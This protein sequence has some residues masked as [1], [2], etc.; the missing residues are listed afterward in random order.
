M[1]SPRRSQ[2]QT[3]DANN[4]RVYTCNSKHYRDTPT[5]VP[6]RFG[7]TEAHDRPSPRESPTTQPRPDPPNKHSRQAC[8]LHVTC[9]TPARRPLSLLHPSDGRSNSIAG[10]WHAPWPSHPRRRPLSL[11]LSGLLASACFLY[12]RLPFPPDN[13]RRIR[14]AVRTG[15]TDTPADGKHFVTAPSRA[16]PGGAWAVDRVRGG[17]EVDVEVELELELASG[18]VCRSGIRFRSAWIEIWDQTYR[19]EDSILPEHPPRPMHLT[20]DHRSRH[21]KAK[22]EG[23]IAPRARLSSPCRTSIR[24]GSVV[25]AGPLSTPT[26]RGGEPVASLDW[27]VGGENMGVGDMGCGRAASESRGEEVRSWLDPLSG[28]HPLSCGV[29]VSKMYVA[30]IHRGSETAPTMPS[31]DWGT[32][33]ERQHVAHRTRREPDVVSG[34]APGRG[35]EDEPPRLRRRLTVFQVVRPGSAQRRAP[36]GNVHVGL[37][38]WIS[39]VRAGRPD[40]AGCLAKV[41][42][43]ERV[44]RSESFR[45]APGGTRSYRP[46]QKPRGMCVVLSQVSTS[47][48]RD[49]DRPNEMFSKQS[50]P[51]TDPLASTDEDGEK[52][53]PHLGKPDPK[54]GNLHRTS[55]PSPRSPKAKASGV[56][57]ELPPLTVGGVAGRTFDRALGGDDSQLGGKAKLSDQSWWRDHVSGDGQV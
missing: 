22:P 52:K 19:S 26:P 27:L 9:T 33:L 50:G 32:W 16:P 34:M 10:G 28:A 41:A 35:V 4:R 8:D 53:A 40:G 2:R 18:C 6:L 11:F 54:L 48:R 38:H 49:T 7:S 1:Q 36:Q 51:R 20:P 55:Y 5:T 31:G 45:P 43:F 46:S 17:T 24:T 44:H 39:R 29:P 12:S 47:T 15:D 14:T 25:T 30:R 42:G 23:S 13:R 57:F 56:L 21:I 3:Y 37:D